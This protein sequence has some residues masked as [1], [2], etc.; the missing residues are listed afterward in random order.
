MEE[1]L[2]PT[3]KEHSLIIMDNASYYNSLVETCPNDSWKKADIQEWL[4]KHS[5]NFEQNSLKVDILDIGKIIQ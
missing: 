1:Q 5:I 4:R 3:L 2:L